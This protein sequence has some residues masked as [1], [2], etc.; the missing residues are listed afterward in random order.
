[1]E[2]LVIRLRIEED[3][4][5]SDKKGHTSAEGKANFI[6]LSQGSKKKKHNKGKGSKLGP[7]GRISKKKNVPMEM[8]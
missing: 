7:K 2:D 6:E 8:P 4:K 3:N 5:G 1:M